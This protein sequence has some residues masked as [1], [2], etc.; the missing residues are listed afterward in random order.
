MNEMRRVNSYAI[1]FAKRE[2]EISFFRF[3]R[4]ASLYFIDMR[5]HFSMASFNSNQ[6]SRPTHNDN[7]YVLSLSLTV[8]DSRHFSIQSPRVV[9]TQKA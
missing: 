6:F 7:S 3:N 8:I 5:D 9:V 1:A 4:T 2:S